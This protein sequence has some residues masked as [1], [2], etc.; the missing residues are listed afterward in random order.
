LN[1]KGWTKRGLKRRK[2]SKSV[3]KEKKLNVRSPKGL[4][5]KTK[6]LLSRKLLKKRL[7]KTKPS[8]LQKNSGS[9]KKPRPEFRRK[10]KTLP[11]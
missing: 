4:K 5:K 2:L 7:F 1:R 8:K 11:I 10:S 3:S 9:N 6:G